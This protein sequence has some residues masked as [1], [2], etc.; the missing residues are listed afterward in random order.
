MPDESIVQGG[1]AEIVEGSSQPTSRSRDGRWKSEFSNPLSDLRRFLHNH[2]GSGSGRTSSKKESTQKNERPRPTQSN[3]RRGTDSPPWS[4]TNAGL[5]KKYGKFGKTLGVG[6]GGTVRVIKRSKDHVPLAV[7]EFRARCPDEREKDY[8]KK[9]TAEFC[10]GSTLHHINIISTLD[11]IRDNNHYYQVMEYAPIELFAV[12]MSGKMGFNEIN[13]VFRQIV[14]GVDYLHGLGLAHR[15]LKIDNCVMTSDGIVKIIDFGTATVFQ[16]PGKSALSATGIVGSDPYLAPEVLTRQT[17]DARMTDIWSL[18]IVYMCMVLKR[19]PWKIPDPDADPSFKL[20]LLAHP[21]LGGIEPASLLDDEDEIVDADHETSHITGEMSPKSRYGP[22]LETSGA[23]KLLRQFSDETGTA[24]IRTAYE[25]GYDISAASTNNS[26]SVTPVATREGTISRE[27]PQPS[28]SSQS[29]NPYRQHT[30]DEGYEI[31]SLSSS[32]VYESESPSMSVAHSP[33]DN[34]V[35]KEKGPTDFNEDPQPRA[36]DSIFRI[37]PLRSRSCLSRMLMLDPS[38]RATIGDLLRGRRYGAPD[39]AISATVYAQQQQQ[40]QVAESAE[41]MSPD[42]RPVDASGIKGISEQPHRL[43]P[44]GTMEPYVDEFEDDEDF[45]DDWLKSINTC[46]HWISHTNELQSSSSAFTLAPL[47]SSTPVPRQGSPLLTDENCFA[48]MGFRSTD[49]IFDK[50][51][52]RPPPNHMHVSQHSV[53]EPKRRL[54]P[55]RE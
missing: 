11:I 36:A 32:V 46:S 25:A 26:S 22:V 4:S 9:V 21:E 45:G 18:A 42:A 13:C 6:A 5:T 31:P 38:K 3:S 14:D 16:V 15:D 54:F 17:Y 39:S 37:L 47:T 43:L 44:Y 12:V 30:S 55:R 35:F 20:F 8:I 23:E 33:P 27:M 34:G 1:A 10:I 28:H 53:Q 29:L 40:Q 52:I 41:Q 19:F 2:L 50:P 49:D 51:P 24:Q 48:D 7:K